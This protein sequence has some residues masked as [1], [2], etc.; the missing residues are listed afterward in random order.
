MADQEEIRIFITPLSQFGD[1]GAEI[2]ITDFVEV[3]AIGELVESIDSTDFDFGIFAFGEIELVL[4]NGTGKFNDF[5]DSRSIFGFDRDQAI[6]RIVFRETTV[7][8][9][10]NNVVT[11]ATVTDTNLFKGF[12]NDDST[13]TDD[14]NEN[15]IF[16][17]L[18]R[19]SILQRSKIA[20]DTVDD[21]DLASDAVFK[22]LDQDAIEKVL[23]VSAANI[24]L[25]NDFTIDDGS[26]F[27]NISVFEG[28]QDI[29]IAS[30]SVLLIDTSDNILIQSRD[31]NT[32][33]STIGLFGPFDEASKTNIISIREFNDGK[34]RMFNSILLGTDE[35]SDADLIE[36]F[37]LRQKQ[38]TID[39]V[40]TAATLSSISTAL[41]TEFKTPR[42]ECEVEVDI[43]F[44]KS[45]VLLQ[46]ATIDSP[47]RVS[48]PTDKFM[49]TLGQMTYDDTEE[50]YPQEFGSLTISDKIDWK[51]IEKR[52]DP[53]GLTS[54]L[55]LRQTNTGYNG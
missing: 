33:L 20:L 12:V 29:M 17:V 53:A 3:D 51:I 47:L 55:K 21:A 1:F 36:E 39:F 14:T 40:T 54:V 45:L 13:R 10:T 30:N 43:S 46:K 35:T 25:G 2:E 22:I 18:S 44:S 11:A 50:P 28:L 37:G 48:T 24:S 32:G 38:F 4:D 19:E 6:V 7:T 27:D 23:N 52:N 5:N 34:H 16:N 15:V 31:E 8:R 49:A 41:L 26:K 9:D 42:F